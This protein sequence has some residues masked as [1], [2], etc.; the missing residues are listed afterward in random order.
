MAKK[1]KNDYDVLEGQLNDAT[2]TESLGKLK[3]NQSGQPELSESEKS[4]MQ[5]FLDRSRTKGKRRII[6]LND[7]D[8]DFDSN[9]TSNIK[10]GW[11]PISREELGERSRFYP[12]SWEFR[13]RPATV[14]SIK[15]WSAIDE[16]RP[17]QV[18][19]VYNEILKSNVSI[20]DGEQV[21]SYNQINS[22]D[23]FF[24][25]MKVRDYTFSKGEAKLEF[26]DECA[27]CGE[28]IRF[29]LTANALTNDYPDEDIIE[30]CWDA[31]SRQWHISPSDYNVDY[32]DITLYMPTIG[33]EEMILQYA[34]AH[35]QSG[36][37][38]D[39]H[40][41]RFLKF[42]PWLMKNT[43][44]NMDTL[45]SQVNMVKRQ[46]QAWSLDMY[47][48]MQDVIKNIEIT[49]NQTLTAKCPVC[50]AEVTSNIKFQRGI[51]YLFVGENKHRKF[52][53]K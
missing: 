22:A 15:N 17:E 47:L 42:L 34:I 28:E 20:R 19:S 29:N 48:F 52:G 7:I 13:V 36:K 41:E 9:A 50:N 44:K 46:Y 24:F 11:I 51:K 31:E 49:Q 25:I 35:A 33:K 1:I 21:I 43:S 16:V 8:D 12:S 4:E 6:G 10:D 27:E 39:E 30:T 23:R 38:I 2:Q 37:K 3:H 26:T 40:F 32:D 45:E 5:E 18:N 14:E 53:S